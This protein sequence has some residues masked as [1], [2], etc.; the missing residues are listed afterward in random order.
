MRI[1]CHFFLKIRVEPRILFCF[2]SSITEEGG[3]GKYFLKTTQIPMNSVTGCPAGYKKGA[4]VGLIGQN[5]PR[6]ST[7]HRELSLPKEKNCG[8]LPIG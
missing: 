2:G 5:V 6:Y 7:K 8:M 3:K 1:K 4:R